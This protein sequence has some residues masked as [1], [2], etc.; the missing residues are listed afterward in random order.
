MKRIE[1][2]EDEYEIVSDGQFAI[3]DLIT[4]VF[5]DPRVRALGKY[6]FD[7]W[8]PVVEIED[9]F[10]TLMGFGGVPLLRGPDSAYTYARK[11]Q[12]KGYE[13]DQVLD[14]EE[15]LL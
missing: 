2:D 9:R 13:L 3:G 7:H 11:V 8:Y 4:F 10:M 5:K 1:K 15:D 12:N 6:A 14:S